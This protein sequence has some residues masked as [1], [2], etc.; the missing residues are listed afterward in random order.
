[1]SAEISRSSGISEVF[2]AGKPAWHRLGVNVSEAQCWQ[3]ASRLARMDWS[4]SKNQ[5]LNPLTNDV[6]PSYALLRDDTNRWI[7]TVGS[8]YRVIQNNETFEFVDALIGTGKAHYVSAGVLGFGETVWCLAKIETK[9]Q[10]VKGDDHDVYLL[11]TDSRNGKAAKCKITLTRVVCNNTLNISLR[12]NQFHTLKI[13][14]T[15]SGYDVKLKAAKSLFGGVENEIGKIESKLKK[16]AENQVTLPQ[17]ENVMCNLFPGWEKSG[18][19]QNKV[20]QVAAN[21]ENNDNDQIKGIGGSAYA[22]LQSITKFIDHQRV[23]LRSGE[24]SQE[25]KRSES[26]MF[27]SGANFK[28]EALDRICEACGIIDKEEVMNSILNKVSL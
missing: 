12:D 28:A 1:M 21:F 18:Q 22:L 26:A 15:A 13:R 2:V 23:G 4:I 14:H 16:L 11:F 10:P 9:F 6:I 20:G 17:F 27:G 5:L 8:G 24:Q 25:S 3:D 19:A 7:S